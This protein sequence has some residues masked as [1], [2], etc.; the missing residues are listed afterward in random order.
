MKSLHVLRLE[1]PLAKQFPPDGLEGVC[2]HVPLASV[3]EPRLLLLLRLLDNVHELSGGNWGK[4]RLGLHAREGTGS[5][6]VGRRGK[7]TGN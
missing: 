7:V 3:P 6:L 2:R 5:G 1:T 4:Q